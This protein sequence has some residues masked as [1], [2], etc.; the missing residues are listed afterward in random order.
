MKELHYEMIWEFEPVVVMSDRHPLAR[1]GKVNSAD[2]EDYI[3]LIHGDC[4]IPALPYTEV[5]KL[6]QAEYLKRRIRV[7]ERG[8]QFDLLCKIPLTYMWSRRFPPSF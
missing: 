8:S 7:Y 2:L 4:D 6:R 3:E 1:S 5:K